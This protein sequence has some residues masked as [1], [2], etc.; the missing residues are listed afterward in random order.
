MPHAVRITA[1]LLS[2]SLLAACASP[3]EATPRYEAVGRIKAFDPAFHAL[4]PKDARIEKI[5]EGFEWSEGPAWI[6]NGDYLLF[7]DVPANTMHRWSARDGAS[8]FL[9]PSG[10]DGTDL[11]GLRE[12]GAN[13]LEAEPGGT[14][15]LADSGSRLIARFN[16][17]DKT[18]T[19][20]AAT[21]E[22]KRFNSP[23]DIAR[24]SDGTVFFTD[25]PYGLK[26]IDESPLKEQPVN[27][28]YRLDADGSVHLIEGALKFPNGVALSPDERTLY[29]A[30]SDRAHPVWMAYAIDAKGEVRDRRVLA[31]ASDLAAAAEGAPDGLCVSRDGHLFASAPGGLL[32]MDANGKRLGMIETGARVSNCA[33]GD[34][35]R[36]LYLTSHTFVARVRVTAVGA[37]FGP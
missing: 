8:V 28:V 35:G 7:N 6:A 14:V 20:L 21:F 30:N 33:F 18:R 22:G 27:G 11:S 16:P 13:G 24:R 1:L 12:A 26:G 9:E 37:G 17:T 25:P 32:V 3:H 23:N 31:D 2:C 34:D 5:A 29:V 36:T 10:Y 15:L 4:V 19:T